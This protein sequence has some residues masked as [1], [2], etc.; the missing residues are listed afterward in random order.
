MLILHG[1]VHSEKDVDSVGVDSV[2]WRRPR[3]AAPSLHSLQ[4]HSLVR[5]CLSPL[6]E[7]LPFPSHLESTPKNLDILTY[8]RETCVSLE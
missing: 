2:S 8:M 6:D 7:L 4:L 3:E 5:L 1:F